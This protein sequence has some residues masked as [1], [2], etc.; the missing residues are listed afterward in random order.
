[1]ASD[2][3]QAQRP[4]YH[5]RRTLQRRKGHIAVFRVEQ[6]AN[7]AATG[8]HAGGQTVAGNIIRLHR[9]GDLPRQNL[10]DGGRLKLFELAVVFQKI[11][12][13]TQLGGG[14][15]RSRLLGLG[16]CS[17]LLTFKFFL[18]LARQGQFDIGRLLRLLDEAVKNNNALARHAEQHACNA[19]AWKAGPHLP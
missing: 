7:L 18:S 14:A 16:H 9:L 8:F 6:A 1:M 11:V 10:L 4:S 19:V 15:G 13:R 17:L 5:P 2:Q 12:K 3:F